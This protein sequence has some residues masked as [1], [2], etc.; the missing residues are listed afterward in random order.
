MKRKTLVVI[1]A[2]ILGIAGGLYYFVQQGMGAQ[3][4]GRQPPIK[5]GVLHSLTG[6]MAISEIPVVEATLLAIEELNERG[7]LLGRRIEAIVVDGASDS[8][9]FAR[10]AE[11]LITEEEVRVVFGC[12]T[13]ASRKSVKQIVEQ[14]NHLLIYPVQHEGM[15]QSPNIIY[16]GAVPNQQIAPGLQWALTHLGKRVFLVA[17]DYVFPRAANEIMKDQ[18]MAVGGELVGE[19]YLLLGSRDV[20]GMVQKIVD[21][22]PD[23][24]VNTING[25]SNQAFF[26]ELRAA[27]I[28]PEEIPT[29]SFS[30]AE[31]E[32]RAFGAIPMEGDYAT[33]NYFQSIDTKA[34]RA[35]VQRVQAR[36]GADHVTSDPMEAAYFGVKLWAQAVE[37]SRADAP[38]HVREAI[39][40]Q[41]ILAPGGL[42]SID[43]ST[44]HTWKA[45]RVGRID[46][47]GQFEIVWTSREPMRPVLYPNYH[48]TK[49]EWDALL[50]ACFDTW[51]GRWYNPGIS[52]ETIAQRAAHGQAW[53]ERLVNHPVLIA[54]VEDANAQH[55]TLTHT[56]IAKLDTQWVAFTH[57]GTGNLAA[58]AL[59]DR[60]LENETAILLKQFRADHPACREIFVTDWFGLNVAMTN[61]TSDYYQ[62]DES[63]WVDAYNAGSGRSF[64]GDIEYD[65]SA[66]TFGIA[67]YAPV[68][69]DQGE[70]IGVVKAFLNLDEHNVDEPAG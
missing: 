67:L 23:V 59:M 30:I 24:I 11:R 32:L 12:W 36:Y 19:E 57:A 26:R 25:D 44:Q 53:L 22:H 41:T 49:K 45:V 33:W 47:E 8:S 21:A 35:F 20:K 3:V 65:E 46:A 66:R 2:V 40:S 18:M 48:R 34:N 39:K 64:Y 29:M 14:Y 70:A 56:D 37:E 42:I 55:G 17:S 51:G 63:W 16:T 38:Q 69:G 5:V 6:T 58:S 1:V 31:S 52:K 13:S 60:L 62:A 15:E 4:V 54:A 9:I 61:P 28:T 43:R 10:E 68:Y 7:G 27:G 50:L